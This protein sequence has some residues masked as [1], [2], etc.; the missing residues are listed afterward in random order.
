MGRKTKYDAKEFPRRAFDLAR[1]GMIDEDIAA[2]LGIGVTSLYKYANQYPKFAK[3]LK[4]GRRPVDF[5]VENALLK[6]AKGFTFTETT[7]EPTVDPETS[8]VRMVVTKRVRKHI[9]PDTTAAIF[10][11]KNRRP[12]LWRDKHDVELTGVLDVTVPN[13]LEGMD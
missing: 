6:R 11:L 1:Q 4:D 10:W 3:A 2:A 5:E 7:E 8:E 12:K 9:A 13:T